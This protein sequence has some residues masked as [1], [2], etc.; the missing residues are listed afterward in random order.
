DE[1]L[2]FNFDCMPATVPCNLTGIIAIQ[3]LFV[4]SEPETFV[5][6]GTGLAKVRWNAPGGTPATGV[7][8]TFKTKWLKIGTKTLPAT[9]GGTTKT[10]TVIV[11][12]VSIEINTPSDKDNIVQLK[13]VHP[14]QRFK[15]QCTIK[16]IGPAADPETVILKTPDGRLAFPD[17]SLKQLEL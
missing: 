4:H 7:G 12:D 2:A 3:R 6:E 11:L 10:A 16:L 13:S 5:A 1:V 8:P 17:S 14:P 9:C 15:V